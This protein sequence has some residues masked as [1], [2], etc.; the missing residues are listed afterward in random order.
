ML[1][2]GTKYLRISVGTELVEILDYFITLG[3]Q[4][5]HRCQGTGNA[6]GAGVGMIPPGCRSEPSS[7]PA[8]AQSN[9]RSQE[10]TTHFTWR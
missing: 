8:L 6:L 5:R 1:S 9:P 3:L 7:P 4:R 2:M 10:T